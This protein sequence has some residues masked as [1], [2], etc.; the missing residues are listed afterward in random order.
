MKSQTEERNLI[1]TCLLNEIAFCNCYILDL[2]AEAFVGLEEV[3]SEH[4]GRRVLDLV[5]H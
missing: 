1:A 4:V 5:L 2:V 3:D